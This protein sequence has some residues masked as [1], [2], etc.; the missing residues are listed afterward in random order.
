MLGA[1]A[2]HQDTLRFTP[3]FPFD[4][5]RPYHVRLDLS[6]LPNHASDSRSIAT[7]HV[8]RPA[9]AGQ[10]T[11]VVQR[12]YPSS[13]QVPEN[14]LRMYVEFSAPMARYGGVASLHLLDD[15][16]EEV[17]G[18]FL[19]LDYEFWST[20]GRRF[21]VFFDPGR[22]KDGIL[23]NQQMGRALEAGRQYTLV[24]TRDWRDSRGFPLAREY[25][26]SLQVGR[27]FDDGLT[28]SKWRIDAPRAGT[29]SPL[30]VT[31]PR[32]LDHGLLMRALGLR[33]GEQVVAGEVQVLPGETQ[34]QFT[35]ARPWAAGAYSLLAL[36]IL[37]DP[38]GNRIGRPFEIENLGPLDS[39][40]AVQTVRLPVTVSES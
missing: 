39:S 13:V 33:L 31:F 6:Q 22:V 40:P 26:H 20:D 27:A 38:A 36:S 12:V 8:M 17:K 29:R 30:V 3:A 2:R 7:A 15:T 19:P 14:L 1:Y 21:T 4:P 34:W 37:E 25:R 23:P 16:G 9:T 18:A 10:P 24:I 28:P 11:T 35:P 32:P 5:G